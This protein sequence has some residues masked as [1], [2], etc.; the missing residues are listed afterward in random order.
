M[1]ICMWQLE[2]AEWIS[3]YISHCGEGR[4]GKGGD[5]KICL[6]IPNLVNFEQKQQQ[7]HKQQAIY[8]R[9]CVYLERNSRNI[10]R[11][12]NITSVSSR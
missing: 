2:R 9:I 10:Y 6:H 12:E 5:S 4:G 8:M 3:V 1:Y 7:Q 11:T